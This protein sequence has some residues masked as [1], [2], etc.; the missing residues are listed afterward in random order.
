[1][2]SFL[3]LDISES[4]VASILTSGER[5]AAKAMPADWDDLSRALGE[6]AVRAVWDSSSH[7]PSLPRALI[8]SSNVLRKTLVRIL[9]L[10]GGIRPIS[11]I[12]RTWDIDDLHEFDTKA[13]LEP[14]PSVV[15]AF[16]GVI[17]GEL[18]LA[19]GQDFDLQR[20]GIDVVRRTFSY[21]CAQGAFRGCRGSAILDISRRWLEVSA[22]LGIS[23]NGSTIDS[24]AKICEFVIRSL[25]RH[26]GDVSPMSLAQ[27]IG[28][29]RRGDSDMRQ[30]DLLDSPHSL[31]N[32]VEDTRTRSREARVTFIEAALASFRE[33]G[34]GYY[35][36]KGFVLSLIEPG[37][38]DFIEFANSHDDGNGAVVLAYSMCSGV[39]GGAATLSKYRGFGLNL[40]L[41]GLRA[42]P[43]FDSSGDISYTELGI[44]LDTARESHMEFRT[45]TPSTVDVEL[46]PLV[47]ASF[48]NVN[49]RRH[50]EAPAEA[51]AEVEDLKERMAFALRAIEAAQAALSPGHGDTKSSSNRRGGKR[52]R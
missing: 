2:K 8:G 30:P 5:A 52:A 25:S 34:P 9:A 32:L 23:R 48:A 21:S 40:Y 10:P 14:E 41:N 12:V 19:A 29:W 7:M 44:M 4:E 43:F 15:A 28:S 11:S 26:E 49:R 18:T 27:L 1:M 33:M 42:H 6:G 39:L 50:S 31:T 38:F 45:R 51:Q 17:I 36:E 24:A 20:A 13:G 3:A 46:F 35:L 22:L 16:V 47:A 37:S